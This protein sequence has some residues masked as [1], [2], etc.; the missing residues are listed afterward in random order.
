MPSPAPWR[1]ARA[2]LVNNAG[3]G[4]G[5][6]L[7]YVSVEDFRRQLEV[8][9]VGTFAV[10]KAFVPALR[11]ARGRI[12]NIGSVG[13]RRALPFVGPHGASKYAIE[14][15]SDALRQEL[16]PWGIQVA[17]VGGGARAHRAPLPHP[18][19]GRARRAPCKDGK[20]GD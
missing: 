9:V 6:P 10:T 18:L 8:N 14:G 16:R 20:D 13:G 4:V 3:I 1:A 12:V 19:R 17:V 5:G 2:G 11:A 7:E 15:F